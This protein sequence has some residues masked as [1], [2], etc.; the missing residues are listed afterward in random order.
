[1][2][3]GMVETEKEGMMRKIAL[4]MIVA[5]VLFA[6]TAFAEEKIRIAGS[7]S[8]IPLLNDL[9]KTYMAENKNVVIEINQKSIEST[10][11]VQSAAAGQIEIGMAS[12]A[13]KDDEK[14]LGLQAIEISR[15]AAAIGVNKSVTVR[16]ISSEN[17]CKVYSGA[18]ATW[19]DLGGTAERITPLTRPESDAAKVVLRAGITC[20]RNLKE[21]SSVVVVPTAPEMNKLLSNRPGSIGITDATAVDDSGGAIIALKLDGVAPT[22]D[23]V[24]SGKYK[25]IKD[26]YLVTKGEPAG[27]VKAFIA[28]I[29]GPK[30]AKIIES[31]QAVPFK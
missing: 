11:G 29:R 13:L 22:S 10:G 20:F 30:G 25:I 3:T 12:R 21:S 23:N 24:K 2:K 5:L 8:M 1:M 18:I 7:G 19:K 4:C 31:N 6:G 14:T 15:V 16:E 17:L 27:A 28:F 9:A 26:N